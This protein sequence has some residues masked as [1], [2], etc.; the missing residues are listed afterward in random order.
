MGNS[1][2]KD[3]NHDSF[4]KYFNWM[5]YKM[6]KCTGLALGQCHGKE[7]KLMAVSLGSIYTQ[8]YIFSVENAR[9]VV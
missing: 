7:H 3:F 2:T 4:I 6:T 9:A 5:K 1:Y 8:R